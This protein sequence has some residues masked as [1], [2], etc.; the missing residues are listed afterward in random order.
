[1]FNLVENFHFFSYFST[2]LLWS[3]PRLRVSYVYLICDYPLMEYLYC[4]CHYH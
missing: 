2:P 3:F 1:M 4:A